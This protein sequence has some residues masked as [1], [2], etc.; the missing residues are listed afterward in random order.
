MTMGHYL[1]SMPRL[2]NQ[3]TPSS[4]R[5]DRCQR[6]YLK[7]IDCPKEWHG[8]L[9]TVIHPSV[10]YLN[11][12]V[13]SHGSQS[14]QA[15]AEEMPAP[16]GD[17]MS[18]L[19]PDMRAENLM[20]YI[21][22][23][24]TYTPAHREMCASLGHNI[25]V[26]ASGSENGEK[27]GSSIWFMTESKD[28]EVVREYFL[29][30]LGHDIEIEKHFAQ[31]NAW[32][33]ANFDVHVVEQ[34]F[35]DFILVP[36]LAAHQVWNRGT[37]TI[38]VAWNRTTPE[39]LSMALNEALPKARLVCRD[40]QYK[41]KALVYYTLAKYAKLLTPD[42]DSDIFERWDLPF[43]KA[44]VAADF[45]TLFGL[46]AKIL[47]SELLHT[48]EKQIEFIPFGSYIT[49]SFCRGN[50]FN[51]FL[52][53]KNC[54]RKTEAGDDDTYDVC[55][56]CY[57]MGRSCACVSELSWCEQWDWAELVAKY[58]EWRGIVI[59]TDG[60]VDVDTSPQPVEIAAQR[61]ATKSLARICQE[62][63][64]R[65]SG[66]EFA[67]GT[68]RSNSEEDSDPEKTSAK[69]QQARRR[70]K[71]GNVANCHVC[72]HKEYMYKMAKCSN[73]DCNE[74][75]C[76]GSLYRAFD[77]MPVAAMEDKNWQC[78]K[79]RKICYC[80]SC[81]RAGNSAYTPTKTCLGYDTLK[82]ADDRSVEALVNFRL[83]NFSWIKA[84]GEESRSQH[85]RRMLQLREAADNTKADDDASTF[86]AEVESLSIEAAQLQYAAHLQ[87]Q[88][89][90]SFDA[91][92]QADFLSHAVGLGYFDEDDA[93]DRIIFDTYQV[94]PLQTAP[95]NGHHLQ[96]HSQESDISDEDMGEPAD[97]MSH[98]V[99]SSPLK[100]PDTSVS[101]PESEALEA[102]DPALFN[103]PLPL[104]AGPELVETQSQERTTV[105]VSSDT[106]G[107]TGAESP[108]RAFLND[109]GDESEEMEDAPESVA[110]VASR[111]GEESMTPAAIGVPE[112]VQLVSDDDAT[113]PMEQDF[114]SPEP[115]ASPETPE[116]E[117]LKSTKRSIPV[118]ASEYVETTDAENNPPAKYQKTDV[119]TEEPESVQSPA[120][121]HSH[122]L[123]QSPMTVIPPNWFGM[124]PRTRRPQSESDTSDDE[125]IPAKVLSAEEIEQA[126]LE[127]AAK[128]GQEDDS[129]SDEGG[130]FRARG[131]GRGRGRGT[132]RGAPRGS[133]SRGGGRGRGRGRGGRG[134]RGRG[135]RIQ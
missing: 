60:Y 97:S 44:Q 56:E 42:E 69:K 125:D 20:C 41:N 88:E 32:K 105:S 22:H 27:P 129:Q 65:R 18:S 103:E 86:E 21:G 72:C 26:N 92:A 7:D 93:I 70:Q 14:D 48:E 16:A 75:Y 66:K 19:P 38:K 121:S 100:K 49:C 33:R 98:F 124:L 50:I 59:A 53:C 34:R 111:D 64:K 78:P 76:Y 51:R 82:V 84:V 68:A 35:G 81:R 99:S 45:K 12:N 117:G 4:F 8:A 106:P 109:Q 133:C 54:V 30:M 107:D 120:L 134:S 131:R 94:G 123:D 79:C 83:H 10:F 122:H 128:A 6:L 25:M 95:Y 115:A 110:S 71:R 114:E 52:T 63:L 36:P 73:E 127:A 1:R 24:G 29:S 5:S 74:S 119:A 13:T 89:M 112:D 91:S 47:L 15:S 58:E 37:R 118:D 108:M 2:A 113:H 23:E 39:T 17:L 57:T 130:E 77:E 62:E 28:R 102:V 135:S 31:I 90:Q 87:A 132:S 101:K 80:G 43:R 3:H 11:E 9:K 126:R 96:T 46:F 85:S 55:M 40:E 116:K 67:L 61:M 104:A